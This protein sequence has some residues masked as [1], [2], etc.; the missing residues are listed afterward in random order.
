MM[1]AKTVA[2][3]FDGVLHS[4]QGGWQGYEVIS[5]EAVPGVIEDIKRLKA[6]GYRV[7]VMTS[8]ALMYEGKKAAAEWMRARGLTVGCGL[9]G[10]EDSDVFD[11]TY[12]KVPALVYIDDRG[13]TFRPGMDLVETVE[14]FTPWM[15]EKPIE[16]AFE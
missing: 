14:K 5:G 15:N 4:Y 11:V 2:I 3:D 12:R 9:E 6:A 1:N 7:V 16:S 8:R 10:D 13:V